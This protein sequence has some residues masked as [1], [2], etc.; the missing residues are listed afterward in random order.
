M[1]LNVIFNYE[2]HGTDCAV[3]LE[4]LHSFTRVV[5]LKEGES[6]YHDL[7]GHLTNQR[8]R[9]LF[10]IEAGIMCCERDPSLTLTRGSTASLKRKGMGNT[11]IYATPRI[12][13][14]MSVSDLHV[15]TPT[16]GR[17]AAMLKT[18][19]KNRTALTKTVRLA[20]FGPGWVIGA[21]EICS[22]LIIPGMYSAVTTCR[23]HHLPYR[24]IK[25]LEDKNPTLVLKLF[26][27]LSRVSARG[28]ESTIQQLATFHSIMTSLAPTK[29]VSR[30][31]MAA[32]QNALK[33]EV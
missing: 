32:I 25:E 28:Q 21:Q 30:A 13:E 7:S 19:A 16:I 33:G 9:G 29:P 2:Q 24:S 14:S 6:L 1:I 5:E 26:K 31:T 18:L 11:S 3:E 17:E 22:Q 27:L 12:T 10:F 15:R 4:D 8:E 20:R 23:L